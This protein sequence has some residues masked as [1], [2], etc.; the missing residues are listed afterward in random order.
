MMSS[1]YK[2]MFLGAFVGLL[3]P[4]FYL[5]FTENGDMEDWE[6][7]TIFAA[8]AWIGLRIAPWLA[9]RKKKE[10]ED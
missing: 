2:P 3:I 1:K 5:F 8:C 6:R 10:N 9:S 4:S 7:V